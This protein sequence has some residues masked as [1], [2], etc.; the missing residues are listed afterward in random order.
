VTSFD[1]STVFATVA[2]AVPDQEVLVHGDL[3]LT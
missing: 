3:R 1:L 2:A